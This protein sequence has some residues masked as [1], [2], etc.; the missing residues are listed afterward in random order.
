MSSDRHLEF[1][2]RLDFMLRQLLIAINQM[3][4]N[5]VDVPMPLGLTW[6]KELNMAR[7]SRG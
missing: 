6:W 5:P 7:G 4:P 1:D 2:V 3:I